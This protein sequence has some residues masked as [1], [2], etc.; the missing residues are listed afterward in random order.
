MSEPRLG[1]PR[2]GFGAG[3]RTPHLPY[4][5]E[6]RPA[7]GFFEIISE[8]FLGCHGGRRSALE[9]IAD[10]YPVVLHGVSLS[11][12][13]TDPLDSGYLRRLKRLADDVDAPWVSDHVCW[14]GVLGIN[15][16]DLL[17]LPFTEETLAHVTDRARIVQD[18]L[19]RPLIL[20]NPSS[21]V[22]FRASTLTEWE[23]LARLAEEA[24]CG[25]LLDVNNVHVSAYNHDFDPEAYLRALPHERVVQMHLAGHTDHGTHIIDTHDAP[26]AEPVWELYRTA[27]ELTGGGAATLL[28]R[29][30]RLPP[31]PELMA[32]LDRARAV[33]DSVTAV[34]AGGGHG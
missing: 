34:T 33:A 8:N 5:R 18:V 6:H 12:G 20:E 25:I 9:E 4:I 31:F 11:I 10:H 2:L 23:F 19:E 30:D 17:P 22:E 21:Y 14:T 7:V 32:E 16:H 29:D 26:V 13:S 28:E 15:T 1:T 3:L 27:V 24:D